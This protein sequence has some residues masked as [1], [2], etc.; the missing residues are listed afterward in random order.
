MNIS[1][2]F[3]YNSDCY[4]DYG[5]VNIIIVLSDMC[6]G[7]TKRQKKK[8]SVKKRIDARIKDEAVTTT[9]EQ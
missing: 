8:A 7:A 1:T 2:Q 6:H 9:I 5:T 3:F 4:Y